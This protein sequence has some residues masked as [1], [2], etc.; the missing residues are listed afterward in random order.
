MDR[1]LTSTYPGDGAQNVSAT[2]DQSG[3]GFG[4][5]QLT[6]LVD[7]AGT[8]NRSYDELGNRLSETRQSG[9]S[10]ATSYSCDGARR[11]AN[12]SYPSGWLIM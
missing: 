3:H 9:S 1:R 2:Y 10:T 11:I 12:I 5:G 7:A 6:S 4:I 8:L